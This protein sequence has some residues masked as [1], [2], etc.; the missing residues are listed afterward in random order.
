MSRGKI[1]IPHSYNISNKKEDA[2]GVKGRPQNIS[3]FVNVNK[4]SSNY[5]INSLNFSQRDLVA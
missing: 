1:S 5:F 4:V 3:L 2:S